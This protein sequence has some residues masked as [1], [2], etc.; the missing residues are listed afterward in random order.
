MKTV[1][2][3]LSYKM[4]D[5]LLHHDKSQVLLYNHVADY[6]SKQFPDRSIDSIRSA[7][8]SCLTETTEEVVQE[9]KT[10]TNT[11]DNYVDCI[12]EIAKRVR[13][14]AMQQLQFVEPEREIIQEREYRLKQ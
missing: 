8:L 10:W 12:R 7:I 11:R 2:L 5:N 1:N 9:R 3:S 4:L 14:M 13:K 6:V